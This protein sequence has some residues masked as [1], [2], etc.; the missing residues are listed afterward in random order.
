MK[1][2]EL[3]GP[4]PSASAVGAVVVA[5]PVVAPVTAP[6]VTG[7][8]VRTMPAAVVTARVIVAVPMPGGLVRAGTRT[9]IIP[10]GIVGPV[11]SV[12]TAH[13]A[14]SVVRAMAALSTIPPRAQ[15]VVA[16]GCCQGRA[17]RRSV[18]PD[19]SDGG[20][21]ALGGHRDARAG[22]SQ[23]ERNGS[24]GEPDAGLSRCVHDPAS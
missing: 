12:L 9:A 24:R 14:S 3:P 2:Q 20:A 16:S 5:R 21:I 11:P 1:D 17:L 4:A 22:E 15:L 13:M 19:V 7:R 10:G 6:V 23:R 8:V 18:C